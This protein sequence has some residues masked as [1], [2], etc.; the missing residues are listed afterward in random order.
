MKPAIRV[1]ISIYTLRSLWVF[2]YFPRDQDKPRRELDPAVKLVLEIVII[3]EGVRGTT[4]LQRQ[5]TVDGGLSHHGAGISRRRLRHGSGRG[6]VEA[7]LSGPG[8]R[9]ALPR[10]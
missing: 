1:S 2:T 7:A 5:H 8:D 10:S 9:M 3:S 6:V 4:A